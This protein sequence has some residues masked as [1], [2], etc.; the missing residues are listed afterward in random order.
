MKRR[1]RPLEF[2]M[3]I[4]LLAILTLRAL[5]W[6]VGDYVMLEGSLIPGRITLFTI[7]LVGCLTSIIS[8]I[9]LQRWGRVLALVVC[10]SYAV[11][12]IVGLIVALAIGRQETI[13]VGSALMTLL[14][15]VV[16]GGGSWFYLTRPDVLRLFSS[17]A[18]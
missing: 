17:P 4:A 18:K 11:L 8:L 6:I 15:A 9:L 7:I 13:G 10:T 5:L 12:L 3:A 2:V 14:E 1:G 16:V